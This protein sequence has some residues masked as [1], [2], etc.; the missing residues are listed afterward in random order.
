M[1]AE[2]LHLCVETHSVNIAGKE[3]SGDRVEEVPHISLSNRI[4][5]ALGW[6]RSTYLQ[7]RIEGTTLTISIDAERYKQEKENKIEQKRLE[8][9]F[10]ERHIRDKNAELSKAQAELDKLEKT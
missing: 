6:N 9:S 3:Y 7:G 10:L 1:V 2:N 4:I 8:I 5:A